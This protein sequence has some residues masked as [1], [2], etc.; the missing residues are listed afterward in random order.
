MKVSGVV[1]TRSLPV[2][3]VL[4]AVSRGTLLPEG[5]RPTLCFVDRCPDPA[6]P[7]I[8]SMWGEEAGP[9]ERDR[10]EFLLMDPEA[11]L[12]QS[13]RVLWEALPPI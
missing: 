10:P 12:R 11:P 4:L 2:A 1:L 3:M 7:T 5:E 6:R 13:S 8:C 9:C